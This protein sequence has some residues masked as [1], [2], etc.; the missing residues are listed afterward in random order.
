M[1]FSH[2][3]P[4]LILVQSHLGSSFGCRGVGFPCSEV[5]T[6]GWGRIIYILGFLTEG[7][8]GS[9][10]RQTVTL[11]GHRS[12]WCAKGHGWSWGEATIL[13]TPSWT[14]SPQETQRT[15]CA[16]SVTSIS[17]TSSIWHPIAEDGFLNLPFLKRVYWFIMLRLLL[18]I[19]NIYFRVIYENVLIF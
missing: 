4:Q 8:A 5:K 3:F 11:C 7:A 1:S 13:R 2:V 17:S 12:G 15:G 10:Q 18:Q 14:S 6:L 19:P 9:S 16:F